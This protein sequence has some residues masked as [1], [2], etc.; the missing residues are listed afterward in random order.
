MVCLDGKVRAGLVSVG[1][2]GRDAVPKV[3]LT[4]GKIWIPWVMI[5]GKNVAFESKPVSIVLWVS[6]ASLGQ[7][8]RLGGLVLIDCKWSAVE[9]LRG[10]K[11][12]RLLGQVC[13]EA[14]VS[15]CDV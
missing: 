13:V 3:N 15:A 2:R 6:F 12:N 10:K 8:A 7:I 14:N 11:T 1:D 9:T 5:V 4:F